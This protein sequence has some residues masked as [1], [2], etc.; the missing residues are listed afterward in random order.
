MKWS[1]VFVEMEIAT[2][3]SSEMTCIDL[4]LGVLTWDAGLSV[5]AG[6]AT[7]RI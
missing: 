2:V 4:D 1:K 6:A 7:F 5:N 3:F